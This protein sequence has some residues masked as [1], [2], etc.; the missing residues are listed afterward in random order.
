MWSAMIGVLLAEIYLDEGRPAAA[1]DL[2]D[3]M[4]PLVEPIGGYFYAPELLRVEAEWLRQARQEAD[5]RKVLLQ[6]I[7]TARQHGSWALAVRSAVALLRAPS[8]DREADLKLLG[9]VQQC[10]AVDN[11]TD[12]GRAAGA[13]LASMSST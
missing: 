13:L 10:L 8:A 5:A 6:S 1:R 2:L 4:R 12:Y 9:D 11:D 3:R 7:Q